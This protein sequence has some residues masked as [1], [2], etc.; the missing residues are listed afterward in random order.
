MGPSG[1]YGVS[2]HS[3]QSPS[4]D[5]WPSVQK[6]W[7]WRGYLFIERVDAMDTIEEQPER[8]TAHSPPI[9]L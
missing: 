3:A 2:H 7:G 9:G 4:P 8:T 6:Y 5:C 1:R